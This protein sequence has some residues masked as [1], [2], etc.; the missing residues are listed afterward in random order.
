M[1]VQ[2]A[3]SDN[4]DTTKYA[5]VLY[6]F[7]AEEEGEI[8]LKESDVVKIHQLKGDWCFGE[9]NGLQGWFPFNFLTYIDEEEYNKLDKYNDENNPVKAIEKQIRSSTISSTICGDSSYRISTDGKRSW[10]NAYQGSIRYKPK[11]ANLSAP[12]ENNPCPEK[13]SIDFVQDFQQQH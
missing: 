13:N 9:L 12:K 8:S 11:S 7:D 1:G 6:D 4:A 10:Y 2:F 5:R 3:E